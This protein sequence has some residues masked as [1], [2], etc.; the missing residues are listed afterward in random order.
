MK[1]IVLED[2]KIIMSNPM[3]VHNYFAWPSV[4]RLRNG[5]LA[6]V[7]SGFRMEHICPFGK[8][9]MSLSYDEGKSWTLPTPIIDTTL[10]DRDGGILAYGASGVIVTSFNNSLEQQ[11]KWSEYWLK[12]GNNRRNYI[13]GYI[14]RIHAEEDERKYLG[15]TFRISHDNGVSWGPLMKSPITCPHGPMLANDGRIIYI[16]RTFS[17]PVLPP[18][19]DEIRAYEV[20]GE[21]GEMTYL[22]TLPH[23]ADDGKGKFGEYEPHA[24]MLPSGKIIVHVRVERGGDNTA[25]KVFTVAQTESYDGGKTFTPLHY[26]HESKTIGAPAHILRH[27]SGK[28]ISVLGDRM[29]PF[30]IRALISADDG[31]S[32]EAYTL[33]E[34]GKLPDIGY[35]A[36]V[37]LKDGSLYTVWYQHPDKGQPSVIFGARWEMPEGK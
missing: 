20:D 34:D 22:G 13:N 23:V 27:S 31:E 1:K 2:K 29:E 37:E 3:S 17:D 18:V 10:D 8:T 14:E 32:W 15:S 9:V 26:I 6:A 30:G 4:A 25:E 11:E 19:P 35:P 12:P 5:V 24:V 33:D 16:G 21:T 36:T 28:L 7:A